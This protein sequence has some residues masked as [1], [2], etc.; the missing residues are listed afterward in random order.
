[1][2]FISYGLQRSASTFSFQLLEGMLDAAGFSQKKILGLLPEEYRM[3]FVD[4]ARYDI[5]AYLRYIPQ[6]Q[7]L[8]LKTHSRLTPGMKE[9]IRKGQ[10]KASVSYRSPYDV[11]VSLYRVGIEERKKD[12]S[13]QRMGFARIETMGQA[14]ETTAQL[15]KIA[16]KWLDNQY[17]LKLFYPDVVLRTRETTLRMADYLGVS[18]DIAPV[19]DKYLNDKALIWEY[20]GGGIGVAEQY[21]DKVQMDWSREHFGWFFEKYCK[22]GGEQYEGR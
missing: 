7:V 12:R 5:E 1:M 17:T 11:A 10:I 18:V 20:R 14:L 22:E 16:D 6:D 13:K 2:I 21:L 8:L 19:C 4:F 9:L 3:Q 15:L